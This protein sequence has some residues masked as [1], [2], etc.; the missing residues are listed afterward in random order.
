MESS[1][2]DVF[3][4]CRKEVEAALGRRDAVPG[5]WTDETVKQMLEA[6]I[7]ESGRKYCLTL[8]EK[9]RLS[10]LLFNRFRRL[11]RLQT[12]LEEEGITDI[13]INGGQ[14]VYVE[15]DGRLQSAGRLFDNQ[16]QVLSLIQRIC[17]QAGRQVSQASPLV[18]ARLP[19]GSR[20][21]AVLPPV[22]LDG[23][24]LAIRKFAS[25][26]FTLAQLVRS[27]TL[28]EEAALLLEGAV[29]DRQ[30]IFLSG[31]TGSGKTTMINV[32]ADLVPAGE[33]I[34]TVEDSAELK[35]RGPAN[36][37]RLEAREAN[38]EGKGEISLRRLV[39]MALRLR[40]DRIILGEVR[41]PEALDM[42]Q[43]MNTGHKG[44]M[45]S[46]HGNSA[47]DMLERLET[48]ALM[49]DIGLPAPAI[50]RQIGSA[51]DLVVHLERREDGSRVVKEIRRISHWTQR[52]PATELLYRRRE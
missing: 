25:R 5:G 19:D 12:L 48:L 1:Y 20:I 40:P 23:P 46:G 33:R 45:S 38:Q 52:E 8:E 31:G 22:A 34:V 6:L 50:R 36:V 18:D 30:N 24:V 14:E 47:L 29:S 42:L 11:D 43:A 16:E 26:S 2:P 39:R 21:G 28:E 17:G 49:A 35:I 27:G 10:G 32:L 7:L 15:R 44:A 3:E 37:V 4:A 9:Q 51:L 13:L 41:G